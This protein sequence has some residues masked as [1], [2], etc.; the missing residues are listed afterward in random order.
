MKKKFTM[1]QDEM[2]ADIIFLFIA[3]FAT[4]SLVFLLDI[5]HSF[6][7]WPFSLQFVFVNADPY[8]V[9]VPIGTI[10]GFLLI[11]LLFYA[12]KRE[13]HL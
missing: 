2:F 4:T 3:G 5:R 9:F 1:S 12:F 13:E 10:I 11:K 6:Y 8:F 7:T